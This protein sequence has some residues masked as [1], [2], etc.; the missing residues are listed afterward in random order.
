MEINAVR[1]RIYVIDYDQASDLFACSFHTTGAPYSQ[2]A[3][4]PLPAAHPDL[5]A[6]QRFDGRRHFPTT[7]P[8]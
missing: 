3:N 8:I 6:G 1:G 5:H 4:Y 2:L 7:P